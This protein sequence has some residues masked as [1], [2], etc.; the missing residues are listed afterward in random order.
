QDGVLGM[1]DLQEGDTLRQV[2][3]ADRAVATPANLIGRP[4][5]EVERFYME[6]ALEKTNGSRVEAARMLGIG[7]RTL[8]REMQTRRTQEKVR[9]TLTA[10]GG[11]IAAAAKQL[12]LKPEDLARKLKKW[13]IEPHDH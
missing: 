8:Y 4:L 7:E 2:Q 12:S 6:R 10:A 3:G 5:K 11:D 9:Q 13:G 1:D